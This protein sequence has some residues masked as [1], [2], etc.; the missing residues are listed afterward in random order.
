M[1]ST[2]PIASIPASNRVRADPR[3]DRKRKIEKTA[4]TV[5]LL[6]STSRSAQPV[7]TP[8]GL[9]ASIRAGEPFASQ[10]RRDPI[11]RNVDRRQNRTPNPATTPS[12]WS[13]RKL[14]TTTEKKATQ[15]VAELLRSAFPVSEKVVSSA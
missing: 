1:L 2:G 6:P 12:S 13:P 4:T 8:P 7:G 9:P 11:T 3:I 5:P 10:E 14:V 15:L